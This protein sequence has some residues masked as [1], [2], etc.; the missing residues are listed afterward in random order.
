MPEPKSSSSSPVLPFVVLAALALV[1]AGAVWWVTRPGP[2][3]IQGEVAAPRV[4]VSART[5]GRVADV[6]ADLGETIEAG[7]RLVTLSNPQLVTAHAAAASGL[8]VARASEAAAGA[9]RPELIRAREADLASAEAD[10]RLATEQ[11]AR[12]TELSKQGLRAQT[13]MD[14]SIRNVETATRRVEAAQAQLDLARA[15]A[16]PEER[17]V[18]AAQVAQAEATLAQRQADLDELT[19]TAP[20]AGEISARLIEPG[21]NIGPGTPLF[22]IVDL[23]SAWFTFNLREDLLAGLQVGDSLPVRVPALDAEVEAKITLINVQGQFASWRA[24]R[25]T[26]DFDLRSFELRAR[27]TTPL[28]G[29]RPGMSA[30]I[31]LGE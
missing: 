5:S 16:S 9:T 1:V 31:T 4:D 21:E 28:P 6:T 25:A 2:L 14:Q 3:L 23:D 27:A 26:G 17:A 11:I 20:M 22:T 30:L 10:L 13:L 19:V 29:L 7:V 8:E 18:A 12:D 24:T 15:G